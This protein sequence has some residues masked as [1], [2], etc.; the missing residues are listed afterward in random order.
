MKILPIRLHFIAYQLHNSVFSTAVHIVKT[1]MVTSVEAPV[2][3]IDFP[4]A[5]RK[6]TETI[7]DTLKPWVFQQNESATS[8]TH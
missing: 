6:L 5:D 2:I 7:H 4:T 1:A 3:T 8:E